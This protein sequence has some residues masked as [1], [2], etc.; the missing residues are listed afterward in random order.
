MIDNLRKAIQRT[1][2][3]LAAK[4]PLLSQHAR[5]II[6]VLRTWQTPPAV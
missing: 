5:E 2:F 4:T 1:L 6:E 3:A